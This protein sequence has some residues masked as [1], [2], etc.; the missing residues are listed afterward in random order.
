MGL[1][2]ALVA[3]GAAAEPGHRPFFIELTPAAAVRTTGE[4]NGSLFPTA[5]GE[6]LPVGGSTSLDVGAHVRGPFFVLGSFTA[7][8]WGATGNGS[9]CDRSTLDA[10]LSLRAG[11]SA[12][13]EL[14]AGAGTFFA[15]LG[16]R[17]HA[18][19]LFLSGGFSGGGSSQVQHS[20]S[21]DGALG[22]LWGAGWLRIGLRLDFSAGPRMWGGS[23]GL[24]F[25]IRPDGAG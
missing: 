13:A 11:A 18:Q 16:P 7:G 20:W 5:S 14:A 15:Q 21:A 8:A 2:A 4:V 23:F 9:C 19:V 12:R 24:A 3:G 17:Y 6:L 22:W 10:A 25:S 1:C